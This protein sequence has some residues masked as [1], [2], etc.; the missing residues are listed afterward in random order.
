MTEEKVNIILDAAYHLFGTK[1]FYETKIS[2]IADYAGIAKGTVYLYFSSKDELFKAMTER[3]F[4]RY[5]TSLK[6]RLEELNGYESKLMGVAEHHMNYF[7]ECKNYKKIFFQAPNNDPELWMIMA[8]YIQQYIHTIEG[9]MK[10]Q[11]LSD[12]HF[13]A[14]AY[15]GILDAFKMDI[16]FTNTVTKEDLKSRAEFIVKFFIKGCNI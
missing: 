3:D 2:E 14:K 4:K 1:G 6:A 12:A 15:S 7:Y 8:K 11:G 10:E 16:L 13:K 5:I 9:V